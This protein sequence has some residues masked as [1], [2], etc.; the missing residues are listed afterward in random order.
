M[1]RDGVRLDLLELAGWNG[2]R[3]VDVDDSGAV[4]GWSGLIGGGKAAAHWVDR[5]PQALGPLDPASL[6]PSSEAVA[7][8]G[9]G[10]IVGWGP[11]EY[12][13]NGAPASGPLGWSWKP[14]DVGLVPFQ[15][16]S[17]TVGS[18]PIDIAE[19][20]AVV[21]WSH[22]DPLGLSERWLW[23]EVPGTPTEK[24]PATFRPA[25]FGAGR[26]V[27]GTDETHLAAARPARWDG[28]TTIDHLPV[29]A[30]TDSGYALAAN[31]SSQ[32]LGYL[33]RGSGGS[34]AT[35]W[36]D[37]GVVDLDQFR[38]AGPDWDGWRMYAANGISENGWIIGLAQTPPPHNVRW[39]T[40]LLRP[41][42][43]RLT[44]T[45]RLGT[46]RDAPAPDAVV[47][48]ARAGALVQR[49]VVRAGTSIL[50]LHPDEWQVSIVGATACV[51]GPATCEASAT[52]HLQGDASLAF[53]ITTPPLVVPTP[54]APPGI[55]PEDIV[56]PVATPLVSHSPR[57]AA[58]PARIALR[59]QSVVIP[60]RCPRTAVRACVGR[61]TVAVRPRRGAASGPVLGGVPVR[62]A[63]G[64]TAALR[65]PIG[66]T[67]RLSIRRAPLPAIARIADTGGARTVR[68]SRAVTLVAPPARRG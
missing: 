42:A 40:W 30:D 46:D 60:V 33:H 56:V 39:R 3:P 20:G 62:V 55:A 26:E 10:T 28:G 68:A 63:P 61:L 66:R 9:S 43:H 29:P 32:V 1:W 65:V 12:L 59:N 4:V 51:V 8:N 2:G 67:W 34:Y 44:V 31:R 7:V 22:P 36:E 5:Q 21:G 37:G 48:E 18:G 19:D 16:L 11:H 13:W 45:V 58:G 24:L 27:F 38:P 14:G 25:A 53:A 41:D 64:R 52:V 50:D 57:F 15:P 49:R 17:T 47:V 35:L 54:A 23:D 6:Y